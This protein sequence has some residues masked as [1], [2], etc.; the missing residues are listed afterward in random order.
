M[1]KIHLNQK[2]KKRTRQSEEGI[3]MS[4]L[5]K[6]T[7]DELVNSIVGKVVEKLD[8]QELKND[9]IKRKDLADE[10]GVNEQF[11]MELETKGLRKM[12]LK[13]HGLVFYSRKQLYKVFD[14]LAI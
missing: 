7:E 2:I 8:R 1:R 11:L 3:K 12:Q 4:L 14:S 9:L 6:E 13:E 5:S 10:L